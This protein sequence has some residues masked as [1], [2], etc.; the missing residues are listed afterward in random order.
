MQVNCIV[1]WCL[2]VSTEGWTHPVCWLKGKS[3]DK[4]VLLNWN[5]WLYW[6]GRL[7]VIVNNITMVIQQG[8]LFFSII[9]KKV[10][11]WLQTEQA[12]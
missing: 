1:D 3:K 2:F 7:I 4:V 8:K 10:K 11:K 12:R 5:M 9:A 6:Y